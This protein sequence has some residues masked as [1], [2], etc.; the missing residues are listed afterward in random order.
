MKKP[1][2]ITNVR[3]A[4]ANERGELHQV[5]TV[6]GGGGGYRRAPCATCP[7]RKDSVGE[8][9]AEAFRISASTAY[10]Q[11]MNKFS[12]HSSG[13]KK[14]ATCAGFLLRGARDNIGVRL[15]IFKGELDLTQVSDGGAELFDGYRSMA[16]ANGVSPD[17]P[18]LVKCRN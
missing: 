10:D 4:G 11:A 16:I 8:F 5:V 15:T 14:P 2:T 17:D 9:P 12:C 13:R 6:T 18:A 1:T 3:P 7:W